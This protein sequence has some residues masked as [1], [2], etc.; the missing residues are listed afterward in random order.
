MSD[1]PQF[2]AHFLELEQAGL[3]TRTFRRLDPGRQR[4]VV[5][6]ILDEA[7]THGPS[8]INVKRVAAQAGVS[9]GSLYAYFGSR[10][11][12]LDFAVALCVRFTTSLFAESRPYLEAMPLRD[13]LAAYLT[14]GIEWSKTQAGLVSFLARAAYHGDPALSESVVRPIATAMRELIRDLLARAAARGELRPG[15]DL[16]ATARVVNAALVAIGDAQLLPYLNTYLQLTDDQVP[17]ERIVGA[18]ISLIFR[19]IAGGE[20]G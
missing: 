4:A 12:L 2:Y 13:A 15:L 5:T 19:G 20:G 8:A 10:Q 3:I 14:V 7:A 18:L 16:E 17:A 11:G 1:W 9:V 6:A